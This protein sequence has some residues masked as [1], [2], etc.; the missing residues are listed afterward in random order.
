[1]PEPTYASFDIC[2]ELH[3]MN[4]MGYTRVDAEG[5]G[6][7]GRS[8][9]YAAECYLLERGERCPHRGRCLT[10]RIPPRARAKR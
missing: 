6:V 2:P 8:Q 3:A 9:T 10:A 4:D 5:R 7:F 1:M